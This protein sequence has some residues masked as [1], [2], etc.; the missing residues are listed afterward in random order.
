MEGVVVAR[1]SITLQ[2][3]TTPFQ[4]ASGAPN[5]EEYHPSPSCTTCHKLQIDLLQAVKRCAKFHTTRYC[6]S[7]CQKQDWKIH[8]Q[9]CGNEPPAS[10]NLSPGTQ[11]TLQPPG[12]PY[13]ESNV[14]LIP[15]KTLLGHWDNL[16]S[17]HPELLHET[18]AQI[19]H[20][21]VDICCQLN[22]TKFPDF[23]VTNLVGLDFGV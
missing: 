16:K 2:R 13:P 22:S 5:L 10:T 6:S 4:S 23:S 11:K 1:A 9:I 7:E 14:P 8:K 12:T 20:E 19:K 3:V 18:S 15:L 21:I 17:F